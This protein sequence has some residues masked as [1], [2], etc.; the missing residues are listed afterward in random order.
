MIG[1]QT[2]LRSIG[3]LAADLQASVPRLERAAQG[4]RPALRLNG[5]PYYDEAGIDTISAALTGGRETR[6]AKHTNRPARAG[7]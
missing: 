2:D 7:R 4:I 3:Q 5:V 6:T 1:M